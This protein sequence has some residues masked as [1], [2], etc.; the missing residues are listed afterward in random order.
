MERER[1]LQSLSDD[2]LLSR[3]A[4]LL[5]H[6][7]RC[8]AELVTHISEVDE[9]RLYARE[10]CPSMFVYC[11]ERLHLSEAEAYLR[12]AAARASREHP[13]LLPML[14]DGRLHL[15]G[16]A[17]LA[18][19]LTSANREAVLA[20]AA[21]Q[22]KREIE[23]LIAEL[24]PRADVP[25]LV[26][27]L[28]APRPDA[29]PVASV[30]S[31]SGWLASGPVPASGSELC[32]DRVAARSER[33]P[34]AVGSELPGDRVR[35]ELEREPDLS[36][37]A[38]EPPAGVDGG[39]GMVNARQ[40]TV[41]PLSADRYKVQFTATAELREKIERLKALMRSCVPNG[42]LAAIIEAAVTEKL[43]RL[44]ARRFGRKASPRQPAE[45]RA[46]R[47]RS[48]LPRTT[49]AL[50]KA[51]SNGTPH[52]RHVPASV[53]RA[54]YERDGG[55]CRY[56]D[57]QGRRCTARE[58]LEFHHRHPFGH[59]GAHSV[60]NLCLMC[61]AHNACVAEVV[62]GTQALNHRR[63]DPIEGRR[64]PPNPS[65]PAAD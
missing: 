10:A 17:R 22:S 26:R 20:R 6:S 38:A 25:T 16:I 58:G 9:R 11:T 64:R 31:G 56:L 23:E 1:P 35:T 44:E 54:V 14:A 19:H 13:L 40:A 46:T 27:K 60:E 33:H 51:P 45:G 36:E 32:P 18:P 12:I 24:W 59:G 62:H 28:P 15:S 53:R 61:H 34:D 47:P 57:R 29:R 65:P 52:S 2:E 3:L 21:Y 39:L 8:E 50:R 55:R 30:P 5:R 63:A 41:E 43:Q 49:A 4:E 48:P 42:D 7:R 37:P